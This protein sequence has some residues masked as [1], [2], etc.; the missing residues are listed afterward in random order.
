MSLPG[1]FKTSEKTVP[2]TVPYLF[3]PKAVARKWQKIAAD[4]QAEQDRPSSGANRICDPPRPC[5]RL[6]RSARLKGH[7]PFE[8]GPET[9]PYG[10]R[11]LGIKDLNGYYLVFA[12]DV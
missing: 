10:L 7:V 9:Q 2:A 11:E 1:L 6:R 12:T 4:W 3:A 8:W 5:A